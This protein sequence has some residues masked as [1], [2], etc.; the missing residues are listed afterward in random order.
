MRMDRKYFRLALTGFILSLFLSSA[1]RTAAQSNY[2]LRSPDQKIEIRI[3]LT[4]RIRYD[5]LLNGKPLLQDSALSLK[6]EN[7]TLGADP[8][9][10]D[11]KDD[12]VD[13]WLEPAVPQKSAKEIG[14][15][16]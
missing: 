2:S 1:G 13:R 8:K 7:A 3:R 10:K 14:R 16:H 12:K 11:K 5:V 6:T 15:A 4:D 9:I